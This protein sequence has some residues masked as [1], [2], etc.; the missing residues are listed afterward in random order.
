MI[1]CPVCE[2][3]QALGGECEVC[4]RRLGGAAG[5]SPPVPAL[6]GLDLGRHASVAASPERLPDLEPTGHPASSYVPD[7]TPGVDPGRAEPVDVEGSPIPG[8]ERTAAEIPDDGPTPIPALV[9]CR[10]CRTPAM[11]DERICS[12]CGMRLPV[13]DGARPEAV[14]D[15]R[16]CSCG[17]P[18]HGSACP[19]CGA[20][21]R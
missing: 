14:E 21:V 3:P 5:A 10:Y 17:A 15:T 6:E 12:R 16:L 19:S 13:I 8:L 20:R 9:A 4:G 1:V 2:H 7:Q 11:P 18:V